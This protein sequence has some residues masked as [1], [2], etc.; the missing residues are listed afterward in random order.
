[1]HSSSPN[2]PQLL[3]SALVG[4][5][6][7]FTALVEP[8]RKPLLVHC[9]RMSGSLDDAEDIV[10]DTFI[11]AWNKIGSF[12]GVGPF[13]NWLYVIASR[14]W[15]DEVRKRKKQVLLPL[16][17]SP[18][19]PDS[20]P[21]PPT[22]PVAWLDPLPDAWLTGSDSS[23]ESSY[24]QREMVSLAFMVALQKLNG[25][26]RVVLILRTVFNWSAIEVADALGLSVA[27]VNNLLYRARKNLERAQYV[28]MPPEKQNLDQFVNAWE[29][30]DVPALIELL[31][32]KAT[33][34]MPPMDVWYMG[35]DSI[36]RALQNFVFIPGVKWKLVGVKANGRSAF[37]IYQQLP[38]A[39]SYHAFGLTLPS[40]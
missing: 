38:D 24:E 40:N 36:Q 25:R 8:H 3:A 15:I 23:A 18:A 6:D 16:N 11:R 29:S 28:E 4:N 12:K 32:E 20:P 33:F 22:T 2:E 5:S 19:D 37:A 17:G 9:Y 13:R 21:R 39:S 26:Q 1:M 27:S 34:A 35:R 10:Q 30:G 7:A 14:L 31:H